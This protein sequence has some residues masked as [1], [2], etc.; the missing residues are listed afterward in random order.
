MHL[1]IT[2][3][4]R[5]ISPLFCIQNNLISGIHFLRSEPKHMLRTIIKAIRRLFCMIYGKMLQITWLKNPKANSLI[6]QVT[7]IGCC[8]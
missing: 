4:Y 1:P 5:I 7:L 3:N 2:F 6:I 8:I